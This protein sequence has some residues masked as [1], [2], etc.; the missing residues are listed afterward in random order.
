[1]YLTRVRCTPKQLPILLNA[2]K[3]V[4][5]EMG[6]ETGK[7]A[8]EAWN[9]PSELAEK[10]GGRTFKREKH[11]SSFAWYGPGVVED[12]DWVL[13]EKYTWC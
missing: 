6:M 3:K 2:A 8:I 11:I 7:D 12:I 4:V 5:R 10:S 9:L 1:M 13:N